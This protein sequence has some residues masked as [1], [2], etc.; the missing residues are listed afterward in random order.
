M[1]KVKSEA[2]KR[3]GAAQLPLSEHD[4][5]MP[6]LSKIEL[7]RAIGMLQ[8]GCALTAVATRFNVAVSTIHRFRRRVNETGVTDD[9][10]RPGAP[11]IT[12]QAQDRFIRLQH[13][14]RRF[15]SAAQTADTRISSQKVRN[16]LRENRIRARRPY[17]GPVLN[18][19]PRA[20][21]RRWVINK[22]HWPAYRWRS[23]LFSYE[24]RFGDRSEMEEEG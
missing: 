21:R 14:R 2:L 11:C 24:S 1:F 17:R 8:A 15:Q 20:K 12:T 5:K 19:R 23:I 4:N 6:R 10:P 13:L 16:R 3:K 9:H 7:E 18:R 22:M